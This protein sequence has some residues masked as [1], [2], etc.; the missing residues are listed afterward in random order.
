VRGVIEVGRTASERVDRRT[1]VGVEQPTDPG[2][3]GSPAS[4]ESWATL[5]LQGK[6]FVSSGP[7]QARIE[8]VTGKPA[9][10]PLR[11]Y[12]SLNGRTIEQVVAAVIAEMDR[13]NAW[14][15]KAICMVTTTGRGNVNEWAASA[16][17]Y[18][19]GGDSCIA[20]MQ[21]SGLPSAITLAA[22]RTEPIVA[23]RL[24]FEAVEARVRRMPQERQPLLLVNG[25]SLGAYGSSQIFKDIDDMLQRLDG[26]LWLG[27]PSFTPMHAELLRRRSPSSSVV[28]PVIDNGR[29]IRFASNR[30][31]LTADEFGRP[32]GEWEAPRIVFLQNDTDPVV[33]WTTPLL[34]RR[35]VWMDGHR[36][37]NTPMGRM[38]WYP[39][40]TYWQVLA[41][42]P[43][44]RNVGEG[45]GHKYNAQQVV[46]SWA[47]VLGMDPEDDYSAIIDALTKEN[48][49]PLVK[50]FGI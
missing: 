31:Q 12:A 15:R 41:D 24:L 3:S 2:R 32:L 36:D 28:D 11:V 39:F 38:T 46:P 5:G 40:V 34:W 21:Y 14:E 44:C 17:E 48:T 43:V 1:P 6:R 47:G 25:E 4:R 42:M 50:V 20:S 35:P 10:Q 27:T 37:P 9:M 26:A 33:W 49:L 22:E 30:T 45:Y 7:S 23:S 18:L 16:L 29:H 8:E 13:V 19:L